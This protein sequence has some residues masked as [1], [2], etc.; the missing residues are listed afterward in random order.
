MS[1]AIVAL[2]VPLAAVAIIFAWVP[3]LNLICP[4]CARALERRRIQMK[5]L[6]M[7][8]STGSIQD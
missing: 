6:K 4:P 5:A 1:D 3:L 7:L 8:A 2:I